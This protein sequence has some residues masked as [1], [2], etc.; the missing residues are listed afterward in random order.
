MPPRRSARAAS[1]RPASTAADPPKA[2]R[3]SRKRALSAV[4]E[5]P[6]SKKARTKAEVE[7]DAPLVNGKGVPAKKKEHVQLVSYFNPLPTP[8][9]KTRPALILFVWGAG[10]FGQFG[11]GPDVLNEFDKP[12]R[13]NW[14]EER[15]PQNVFGDD[16]GSIESIASGGLHSLLVDEKGSVCIPSARHSL[17]L[18]IPQVWSCGVNDDAALGRITKDVPDPNNPGQFL[19]VDDLTSIPHALTSLRDDNFRVARAYSGDSICAA[20]STTGALRVWGSFR[21]SFIL[22]HCR[23]SIQSDY[24][25]LTAYS[26][27][28]MA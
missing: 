13:N 17:F 24:R 19:D 14:V 28:P 3:L 4:H 2:V 22:F 15:I 7:N 21:V 8:P 26:A 16:G 23:I 18:H 25:R 12:R 6:P 9:P 27:L 1:A 10:N 5:A 11:M 20:V